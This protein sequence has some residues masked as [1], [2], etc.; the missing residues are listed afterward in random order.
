MRKSNLI[1]AVM[2]VVLA[3]VMSIIVGCASE[4]V[5]ISAPEL[6]P[7]VTFEKVMGEVTA[8]MRELPKDGYK[9]HPSCISEAVRNDLPPVTVWLLS[10]TCPEDSTKILAKRHGDLKVPA[11]YWMQDKP[12][13]IPTVDLMWKRS[14]VELWSSAQMA[15]A[16]P[17]QAVCSGELTAGLRWE[18]TILIE[19]VCREYSL[20]VFAPFGAVAQPE[21]SDEELDAAAEYAAG[22]WHFNANAM[23][24]LSKGKYFGTFA[25]EPFRGVHTPCPRKSDGN[26]ADNC[27]V[28]SNQ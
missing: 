8:E 4:P 1:S 21:F 28:S 16:A 14:F 7:G 23:R 12:E 13:D 19:A 25:K 5:D 2:A 26:L 6:N 18:Q 15:V 11:S 9:S 3:V 17:E 27:F 20:G 22:A 24:T 10:V